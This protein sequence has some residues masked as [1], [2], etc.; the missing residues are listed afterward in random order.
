LA[1]ETP[2]PESMENEAGTQ[3]TSRLCV[4]ETETKSTDEKIELEREKQKKISDPATPKTPQH[5]SD[6]KEQF[7]Y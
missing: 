5:D 3:G 2:G 7:L 6:P 4:D 1:E